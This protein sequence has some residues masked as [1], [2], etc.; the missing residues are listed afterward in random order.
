MRESEILERVQYENL[1][2]RHSTGNNTPVFLIH[3]GGGITFAYNC[4]ESLHRNVYG[5]KN[6]LYWSGAKF[7]GGIPEMGRLYAKLIRKEVLKPTFPGPRNCDE[8]VDILL[9]GWSLGGLLSMQVAKELEDDMTVRVMGD[10]KSV[11]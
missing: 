7:L 4:L 9:G 2:Q 10:R 3:D 11:V 5:I 6:P 8:S 1:Q